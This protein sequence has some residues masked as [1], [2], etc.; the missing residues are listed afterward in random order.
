MGT[1]G[2]A[3]VRRWLMELRLADKRE[4]E[5]RERA[6]KV[7]KRYR[8]E[9][10]RSDSRFNI[11]WSN[12][13]TLSPALYSARPK[14]DVRR[15]WDQP[16]PISRE[17]ALILERALEYSM[18][19]QDFDGLM[20]MQVQDY[21]L[22][23]RSVMRCRYVPT[24]EKGE[25]QRVMLVQRDPDDPE[26]LF[27]DESGEER[28]P[29]GFDDFGLPFA[30]DEP[31]D[32][33]VNEEVAYEYVDWRDFRM[34]FGKKWE[35]IDW[36]AFRHQWTRD[37]LVDAFG[38]KGA[39]VQLDI[40]PDIDADNREDREAADSMKK[41]EVWEIWD[42][43]TRRVLFVSRGYKDGPLDDRDDPLSLVDFY[44]V[45][46]PL[47]SVKTN[48]SMVPIPEFTMYQDQAD[49]LDRITG[50]IDKIVDALRVRGVYDASAEN[51]GQI[52]KGDDNDLIPI[53]SWQALVQKGG[54]DGV[55]SWM[56]IQQ[57]AA[58]LLQLYQQRDQLLQTI[59]QLTGI[60]DIFRGSTDP[61][62]TK[63]AQQLKAQFGSLRLRPRQ[64]E[65]Q[66]FVRDVL[67]ITAE[68]IAENFSP[69]TLQL[70][71]GRPVAPQ[72]IAMMQ[73]DSLR[74]YAIDI[75]TDS[76]IASEDAAEKE[77]VIEFITAFANAFSTMGPLVQQGVMPLEAAKAIVL[78]GARKFKASREVEE[79]LNTIGTVPPQQEGEQ[80]DQGELAV[81]MAKIQQ[82]ATEAEREIALKFAQL[83][84]EEQREAFKLMLEERDLELRER[85]LELRAGIDRFKA[86]VDAEN[87]EQRAMQ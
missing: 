27:M 66:R 74:S 72:M 77:Q 53:D 38:Q 4:N 56:P 71:T 30:T 79:A 35:D 47:Y 45:P 80:S 32:E 3:V 1:D 12:T 78:F 13:E 60:S 61:R 41:A 6:E 73:E 65:V 69:E 46:K 14:P 24:F 50:R 10:E 22:P 57:L 33:L 87:A 7:V 39:S 62:E 36:I 43:A 18:D 75:E 55:I 25:R 49:E 20:A 23:G 67:R 81:E 34:S 15:R 40:T 59:Y 5:W 64:D 63:G 76:T 82:D 16:D 8:D 42:R 19:T 70:M 48:G 68:I 51:I 54:L 31:E 29:E 28:E 83:Q 21:L 37:E 58:V 17:I 9:Q 26:S 84:S 85:E 11:V 2:P 86:V 44:P 52:L